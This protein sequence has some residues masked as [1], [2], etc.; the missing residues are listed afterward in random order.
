MDLKDLPG[1]GFP[2]PAD[3]LDAIREDQGTMLQRYIALVFAE[4][5]KTREKALDIRGEGR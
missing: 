3:K 2:I 1:P 5:E 4:A